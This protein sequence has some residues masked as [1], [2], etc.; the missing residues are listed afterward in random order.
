[1][2]GWCLHPQS[3]EYLPLS[4]LCFCTFSQDRQPVTRRD[5]EALPCL[6]AHALPFTFF[7]LSYAGHP[8]LWLVLGCLYHY[9]SP[10]PICVIPFLLETRGRTHS[11]KVQSLPGIGISQ[12]MPGMHWLLTHLRTRYTWSEEQYH[13]KEKTTAEVRYFAAVPFIF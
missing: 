6:A 10:S 9:L 11:L 8:M 3:L 12:H 4:P 2:L 7:A 13:I 1:M 5:L